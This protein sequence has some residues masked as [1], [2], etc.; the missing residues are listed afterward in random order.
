MWWIFGG[1][2]VAGERF[3]PALPVAWLAASGQSI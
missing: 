2:Q 3:K 1:S